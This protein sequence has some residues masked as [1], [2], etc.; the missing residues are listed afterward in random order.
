[1][2]AVWDLLCESKGARVKIGAEGEFTDLEVGFATII[3]REQPP[4]P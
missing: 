1:V 3:G 4:E 2:K